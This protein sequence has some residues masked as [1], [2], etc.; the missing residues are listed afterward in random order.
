M[1]QCNSASFADHACLIPQPATLSTHQP[2]GHGLAGL[3]GSTRCG[4]ASKRWSRMRLVAGQC[5]AHP[6]RSFLADLDIPRRPI[7]DARYREPLLARTLFVSPVRDAVGFSLTR[8]CFCLTAGDAYLDVAL[9]FRHSHI[10]RNLG[11]LFAL[12]TLFIFLTAL[13]SEATPPAGSKK[14]Y[15]LYKRGGSANKTSDRPSSEDG[16]LEEKKDNEREEG[17]EKGVVTSNSIFTWK[18]LSYTV[19]A[20]GKDLQL[21]DNVQGWCKPGQLTA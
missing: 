19:R 1:A 5:H 6:M 20:N 15:L 12:W 4:T 13:A 18:N 3:A 9:H 2:C 7:K 17:A 8:D 14:A 21:L 16:E 10:W 11:I